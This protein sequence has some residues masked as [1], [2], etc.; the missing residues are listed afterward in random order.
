MRS[1]SGSRPHPFDRDDRPAAASWTGS[2]CAQGRTR[3]RLSNPVEGISA[4]GLTGRPHLERGDGEYGDQAGRCRASR[5]AP[6]NWTSNGRAWPVRWR[7]SQDPVGMAQ[8]MM[9]LGAFTAARHHQRVVVVLGQCHRELGR[10]RVRGTGVSWTRT[11]GRPRLFGRCRCS[12]ASRTHGD[13]LAR[14]RHK[15]VSKPG[16]VVTGRGVSCRSAESAL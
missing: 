4:R 14:R 13:D 6:R 5:A 2:S 11:P 10:D 7:N 12:M 3:A 9:A 8:R 16:A 1:W 15:T